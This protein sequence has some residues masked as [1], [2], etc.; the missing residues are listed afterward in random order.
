MKGPLE[1]MDSLEDSLPIRR[2]L[3]KFYCSKSKSFSSLA[4]AISSI[5]SAKELAKPQ[6]PYTRKRKNLLACSKMGDKLD[7]SLSR[8]IRG[9]MPKR[10][11]NSNRSTASLAVSTSSTI[12]NGSNGEEVQEPYLLH[13]PRHPN[14]RH[15]ASPVDTHPTGTFSFDM[16]SFSMADLQ[17]IAC[18]IPSFHPP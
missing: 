11:A 13:P 2:G 1:T 12:S 10:L 18:S 14:A 6:N 7:G 5:S 16:R 15:F 17:S 9:G 8:T 4:D 3:L